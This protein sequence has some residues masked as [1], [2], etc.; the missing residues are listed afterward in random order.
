M[1]GTVKCARFTVHLRRANPAA[2]VAIVVRV[3]LRDAKV[4]DFRNFTG[5][6]FDSLRVN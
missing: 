1:D 5:V 4:Q 6:M 2:W 3:N